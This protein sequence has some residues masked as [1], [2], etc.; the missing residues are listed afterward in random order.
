MRYKA[1]PK[2]NIGDEG[3][4]ACDVPTF[5]RRH[6]ISR[7]HFYVAVANGTGPAL[8]KIGAR[9]T[10]SKEAAAKWRRVRESAT[11]DR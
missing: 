9:T 11:S 8:M 6:C 7:S 2:T 5:C 4:D 3:A 1:K 10:I